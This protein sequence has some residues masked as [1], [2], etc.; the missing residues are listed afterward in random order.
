MELNKV[1]FDT[2]NFEAGF[3]VVTFNQCQNCN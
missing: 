2:L 1:V 3:T